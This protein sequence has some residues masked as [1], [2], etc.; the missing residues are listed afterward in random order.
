M[1]QAQKLLE[2]REQN[3][4]SVI[5]E[6]EKILEMRIRKS[7]RDQETDIDTS[8]LVKMT[9]QQKQVDQSTSLLT[10]ARLMG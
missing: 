1:E 2:E 8:Q 4:T 7:Q 9:V 10:H 6:K 3:P 5:K